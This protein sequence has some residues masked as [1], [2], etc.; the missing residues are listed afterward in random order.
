MS[1]RERA[2]A[3]TVSP[4]L[5][6]DHRG[7][8]CRLLH[9]DDDPTV[10]RG[11]VDWTVSGPVVGCLGIVLLIG[12][13]LTAVAASNA[14]SRR[15]PMLVAPCLLVLTPP[16]VWLAWKLTHDAR[17]RL[18]GVNVLDSAREVALLRQGRCPGCGYVLWDLPVEADGLVV[19]AECGAAWRTPR[20]PD[21]DT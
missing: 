2:G 3:K 4:R 14:W 15:D 10:E 11:G 17:R 20:R 8:P 5:S 6:R 9:L 19:C 12:G 13:V 1:A 18:R 21:P 16:L 7:R